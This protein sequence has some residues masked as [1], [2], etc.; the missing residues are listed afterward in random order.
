MFIM[1]V[2]DL[3]KK[4]NNVMWNKEGYIPATRGSS[5]EQAVNSE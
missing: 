3:A 2:A 1:M 5:P 4:W